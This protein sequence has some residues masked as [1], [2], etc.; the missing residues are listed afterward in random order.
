MRLGSKVRCSMPGRALVQVVSSLYKYTIGFYFVC[1]WECR[2]RYVLGSV[3]SH[4]LTEQRRFT[5][6]WVKGFRN[7]HCTGQIITMCFNDCWHWRCACENVEVNIQIASLCH[8]QSGRCSLKRR[9]CQPSSARGPFSRARPIKKK[10]SGLVW[11]PAPS[12][13]LNDNRLHSRAYANITARLCFDFGPLCSP[14]A[15]SETVTR[16]SLT[17]TLH[18]IMR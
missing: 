8:R 1:N 10:H 2:W 13:W 3:G 16:R 12:P 7:I 17:N 5:C 11:S 9:L 6:S 18:T 15:G 4:T 14:W